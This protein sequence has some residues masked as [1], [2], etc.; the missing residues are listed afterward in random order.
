MKIDENEKIKLNSWIS[1]PKLGVS[2]NKNGTNA[3]IPFIL[4]GYLGAKYDDD[5]R[6]WQLPSLDF[7]AD[8]TLKLKQ[9][10]ELSVLYTSNV[11]FTQ[12][13]K[14]MKYK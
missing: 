11:I 8:R 13:N 7:H 3:H 5:A 4:D 9:I 2:E 6:K 1:R 14:C 12:I 10:F